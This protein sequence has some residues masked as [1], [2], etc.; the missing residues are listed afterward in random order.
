MLNKN[1]NKSYPAAGDNVELANAFADFFQAKV[2]GILHKIADGRR[3]NNQQFEP[4]FAEESCCSSVFS[5]F[6]PVTDVEFIDPIK[7]NTIKSCSLDALPATVVR[8]CYLTL[9]PPLK[10]I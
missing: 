1:P 8:K 6:V 5:S 9:V 10:N 2:D 4:C 3:V 7:N